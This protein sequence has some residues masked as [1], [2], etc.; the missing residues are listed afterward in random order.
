MKLNFIQSKKIDKFCKNALNYLERNNWQEAIDQY[1]KVIEILPEPKKNWD[2]Y[3]WVY[4]TI[5]DIYFIN[6]E[7]EKARIFLSKSYLNDEVNAFLFLRLGQVLYYLNE[8]AEAQQLLQK[9]YDMEG[10]TIFECE[11]ELFINLIL[12]E[13]NVIETISLNTEHEYMFRLP[14][15]YEYLEDEYFSNSYLFKN[16]DWGNI[17]IRN[18]ELY[19][20]IPKILYDNT[21]A[22]FTV[23]NILESAINL[24]K[25]EVLNDWYDK[26]IIVSEH[27]DDIDAQM[28]WKAILEIKF[29]HVDSAMKI[30][31]EVKKNCGLKQIKKFHHFGNRV[32]DYYVGKSELL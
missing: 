13:V 30:L 28:V 19:N 17:Y 12:G 31:D 25:I 6:E 23:K 15:E 10:E 5:G 7:Y 14:E 32:Y 8:I 3:N 1:S 27:R 20:K 21:L 18:I 11:D 24:D 9:A 29:G 4:T 16:F 22:W 26:L 2:A